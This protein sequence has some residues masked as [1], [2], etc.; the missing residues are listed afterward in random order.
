MVEIKFIN[1]TFS[2]LPLSK[3]QLL[4]SF[5]N[6][7]KDEKIDDLSKCFTCEQKDV[8]IGP[9]KMEILKLKITPLIKGVLKIEGV[10]WVLGFIN[11]F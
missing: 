9:G 3:I 11:I 7:N 1:P 4:A 6:E 2:E 5:D 8:T 10:S